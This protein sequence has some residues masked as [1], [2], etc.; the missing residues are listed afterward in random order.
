[1]SWSRT[2]DEPTAVPDRRSLQ[3]L[4]DTGHFAA[5]LPKTKRYKTRWQ[6]AAHELMMRIANFAVHASSEHRAIERR[7]GTLG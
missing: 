2:L 4:R 3:K 1:M 5:T 6:T 7:P